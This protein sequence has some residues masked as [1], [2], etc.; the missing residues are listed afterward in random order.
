ML[1]DLPSG[2]F[3]Q[4][5]NDWVTTRAHELK[6]RNAPDYRYYI[7]AL[8]DHQRYVWG[9]HDLAMRLAERDTAHDDPDDLPGGTFEDIGMSPETVLAQTAHALGYR[10]VPFARWAAMKLGDQSFAHEVEATCR[11]WCVRADA[12]FHGMAG[13]RETRTGIKAARLMV[14]ALRR[15]AYKLECEV[16]RY[17]QPYID[18]S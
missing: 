6:G 11:D 1:A 9:V 14:G 8:H 18:I 12:V 2:R 7:D 17:V 15:G 4:G 5:L 16:V 10:L 3:E 13:R